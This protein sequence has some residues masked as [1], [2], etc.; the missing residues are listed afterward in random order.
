[1]EK[2]LFRCSVCNNVIETDAVTT[3]CF[4]CGATPDKFVELTSEAAELI[5]RSERSNDLLME[6]DGLMLSMMDLA[7][8][9]I[10]Q[11]LDP[12]CVKLFTFAHESAWQMKQSLKAEVQNH[13]AKGKW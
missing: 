1:M 12:A 4:K 5:Y 7:S 6:L 9:G 11:N 13:I 10:E 2:K 3:N 8:E